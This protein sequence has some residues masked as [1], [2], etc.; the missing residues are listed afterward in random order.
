[1]VPSTESVAP[2]TGAPAASCSST[3]TRVGPTTGG[4]RCNLNRDV[5]GIAVDQTTPTTS[6][7]NRQNCEGYREPWP[8]PLLTPPTNRGHV[9]ALEG[10]GREIHGWRGFESHRTRR[11]RRVVTRAPPS[12]WARTVRTIRP[13]RSTTKVR[14][15][16]RIPTCSPGS[17]C[18][19]VSRATAAGSWVCSACRS[20]CA[21]GSRSRLTSIP[22]AAQAASSSGPVPVNATKGRMERSHPASEGIRGVAVRI[23][24]H[25]DALKSQ[26]A[27]LEFLKGPRPVQERQRTGIGA[28]LNPKKT[29]AGRPR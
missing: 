23:H 5:D 16:C 24:G 15:E 10:G 25:E 9:L 8:H 1:M 21:S 11:G 26:P 4:G 29:S 19:G 12:T 17:S 2:S 27:S 20:A 3:T 14:V 22:Q 13:S 7:Q 6:L 18:R 28:E